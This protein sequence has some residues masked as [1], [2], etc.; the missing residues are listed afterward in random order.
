MHECGSS[1]L[2][3]FLKWF[4]LLVLVYNVYVRCNMLAFLDFLVDTRGCPCVFGLTATSVAVGDPR[5]L[6][7]LQA[8][9]KSV[10]AC[11][12]ISMK[13]YLQAVSKSVIACIGIGMKWYEK[14]LLHALKCLD[15]LSNHSFWVREG[16]WTGSWGPHHRIQNAINATFGQWQRPA[17]VQLLSSQHY[18]YDLLQI[19]C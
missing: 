17:K 4:L 3:Q 5:L 9:T 11:I 1:F 15:L 12:G 10:I 13:W 7:Y 16:A 18:I 8:A 14:A 19:W 2:L 6:G